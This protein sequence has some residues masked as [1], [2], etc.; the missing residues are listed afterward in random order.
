SHISRTARN[1]LLR[2]KCES[3]KMVPVVTENRYRQSLQSSWLRV[4]MREMDSEPQRRQHTPEGQ[5]RPSR[6]ARHSAS[7]LNLTVSSG[8]VT[9][10]LMGLGLDMGVS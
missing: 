6:A 1:H 5:R 9:L 2:A 10:A 4:V 8:S 7:L 3:L